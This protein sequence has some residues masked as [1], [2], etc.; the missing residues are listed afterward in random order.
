MKQVCAIF[1]LLFAIYINASAQTSA[2]ESLQTGVNVDPRAKTL[3]A[4]HT[5]VN[6]KIKPKGYRIQIYFGADKTTAKDV[7]SKFLTQYATEVN[8]YE[9]YE[10]PNF[11]V[12]VGD[13]R[14]RIEAY[15]FLKKIREEYPSA[16]IVQSE[17]EPT[18]KK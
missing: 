1:I 17:I 7:K 9:I 11:K 4:K 2:A 6:E 12:R 3:I 18:P 14:N 16:F 13:F 15:R 10:V 5:I 8:A